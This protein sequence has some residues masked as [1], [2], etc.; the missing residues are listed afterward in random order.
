MRTCLR[1]VWPNSSN[2]MV[3]RSATQEKSRIYCCCPKVLHEMTSMIMPTNRCHCLIYCYDEVFFVYE[4]VAKCIRCQRFPRTENPE[5]IR[6]I[7]KCS[8]ETRFV[9][10]KLRLQRPCER[11]S[12]TLA[13]VQSNQYNK[14][15]RPL[16]KFVGFYFRLYSKSINIAMLSSLLAVHKFVGS[17]FT[18]LNFRSQFIGHYWTTKKNCWNLFPK[19]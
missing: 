1:R 9:Q 11:G 6:E 3:Y 14:F 7:Q 17:F 2:S 13:V 16:S 10:S 12:A 15:V 5:I 4:A 19:L 8:S 18:S